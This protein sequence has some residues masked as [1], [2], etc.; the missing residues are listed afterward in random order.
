MKHLV[1]LLGA[2][3]VVAAQARAAP[4]PDAPRKPPAAKTKARAGATKPR[5][6]AK[7]KPRAAAK[8]K[9][10][11]AVLL[12]QT[13]VA[14][15]DLADNLTEVLLVSLSARGNFQV[16]GKEVVKNQLGGVEKRVLECVGNRTCV[17]NVATALA[18]D[19]LI[20]GTLG[21]LESTWMY[22]LYFIDA[23]SGGERKRVHRRVTG[24]L[25]KLT[26]SLDKSLA[27]LLK[28]RVKPGVV[29]VVGNVRGAKV[30]IDDAFA[31]T[32][33][34]RRAGLKPGTIRLRI[35]ADGYFAAE[36]T[37][38]VV[39]GKTIVVRVVLVRV[40]PRKATW[41]VYLAW[42]SFGVA[43]A[44]AAAAGATGGLSRKVRGT[45]HREQLDDLDRRLNLA[46][47]ANVMIGVSAAAAVTSAAL[48]IFAR[49][50]FYVGGRERQGRLSVS[51]VPGGA[52]VSGGFRW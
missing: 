51:P 41:K 11:V 23:A 15:S 30:H 37:V 46:L 7:R 3:I 35:E 1:I 19:Y 17:G 52:Y 9:P 40:P 44:A 28:P 16:V 21:K 42:S 6:A 18:L 10:R 47:V 20:V 50:G 26:R 8:R 25:A 43:L 24:D 45:T 22:N 49:K 31:G 14:S 34:L 33:P 5:A 13:G 32:V 4:A 36:R 29:R 2:L 27:E 12:M 48:F 39:P 38:A